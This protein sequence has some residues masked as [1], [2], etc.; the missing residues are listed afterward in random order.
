[1]L[2][3]ELRTPLN[4]IIGF[5]EMLDSEVLGHVGNPRYR[6]YA[7]HIIDSGAH[8]RDVV[9]GMLTM[10]SVHDGP[11]AQ[12]VTPSDPAA[13]M[14]D[15]LAMVRSAAKAAGVRLSGRASGGDDRF[16]AD[17]MAVS[18]I[19]A[20]LV[21]DA[22]VHASRGDR[23]SL[24]C[25]LAGGGDGVLYI[26]ENPAPARR[27]NLAGRSGLG[28]SFRDGDAGKPMICRDLGPAVWHWLVRLN[29]GR[30]DLLRR[31][32][33]PWRARIGFPETLLQRPAEP[34]VGDG[35]GSAR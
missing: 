9:E 5:A 17:P 28:H 13:V 10:L 3:H 23:I 33:S 15:G 31:P 18:R 22:I 35:I 27:Q 25:R 6:D 12:N 30:L 16:L 1:M 24:S 34:P 32:G 20:A 7:R 26:I 4:A 14:R 19:L 11:V 8:L 2:S 29:G 21:E